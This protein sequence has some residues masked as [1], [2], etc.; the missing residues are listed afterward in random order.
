MNLS[1]VISSAAASHGYVLADRSPTETRRSGDV[2]VRDGAIKDLRYTLLPVFANL[3]KPDTAMQALIERLRAP[4]AAQF[5]ETRN[6]FV[7]D[8]RYHRCAGPA[9]VP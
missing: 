7:T 9:G 4:H 6:S 1:S 2:H 3:I 8:H 5:A